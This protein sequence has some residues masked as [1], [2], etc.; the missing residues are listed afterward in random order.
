MGPVLFPKIL[1][2]SLDGI[3]WN[4][5]NITKYIQ[6]IIWPWCASRSYLHWGCHI[7]PRAL[8]HKTLLTLVLLNSDLSSLEDS[9]DSEQLAS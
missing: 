6:V 5:Q 3:S 1:Y 2:R 9:V 8:I 7:G 4:V